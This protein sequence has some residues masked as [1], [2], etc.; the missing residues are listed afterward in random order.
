MQN[1]KSKNQE[2]E[3]NAI[4]EMKTSIANLSNVAKTMQSLSGRFSLIEEFF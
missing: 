1:I 2:K 3:N 4:E